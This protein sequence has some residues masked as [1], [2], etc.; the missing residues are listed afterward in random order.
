MLVGVTPALGSPRRGASATALRLQRAIDVRGEP[1]DARSG[2]AAPL[3]LV[4]GWVAAQA[5]RAW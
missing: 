4:D 3:H 5:R 1:L 2:L